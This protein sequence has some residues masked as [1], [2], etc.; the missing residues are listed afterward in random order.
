MLSK[1]VGYDISCVLVSFGKAADLY[2]GLRE[3]NGTGKVLWPPFSYT[4]I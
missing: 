1:E 3:L 2:E 4:D